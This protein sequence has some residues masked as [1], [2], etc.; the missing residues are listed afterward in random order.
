M[1][2]REQQDRDHRT[3]QMCSQRDKVATNSNL[4]EPKKMHLTVTGF[5]NKARVFVVKKRV[6]GN[7]DSSVK[8]TL[9]HIY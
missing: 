6:K 1:T 9:G 5:L 3:L 8:G 7:I 2:H 4:L